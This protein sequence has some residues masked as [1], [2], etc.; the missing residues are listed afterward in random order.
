MRHNLRQEPY[1]VMPHVR[2][3][4]GGGRRVTG[5]PTATLSSW[6]GRTYSVW[7]DCDGGQCRPVHAVNVKRD[8]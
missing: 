7:I 5:V 3:C 8:E 6:R 4:A 1:A 2:I